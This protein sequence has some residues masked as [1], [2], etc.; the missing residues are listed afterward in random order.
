MQRIATL[1][2]AALAVGLIA[3]AQAAD[4][5]QV[6][7]QA[8]QNNG[9]FQAAYQTYLAAK[10]NVPIYRGPLLPQVSVTSAGTGVTRNLKTDTTTK[11]FTLN[12]T[13]VLF[14]YTAW[15]TY[16]QS[17]YQ[18]KFDTLTY[19]TAEQDLINT[20]AQDYFAVL[21][22][23]DNLAYALAYERSNKENLDQATEQFKVGLKAVTDV[24]SARAQYESAVAS[25]IAAQNTLQDAYQTLS[26]L[27][28]RAEISLNILKPDFPK[29]EPYP[30]EAKIWAK[31]AMKNNLSVLSDAEQ[32][33]IDT[34]GIKVAKSGFYPTL[35]LS[36]NYVYTRES[37]STTT[38]RNAAV[39]ASWS[40]Y[41]GGSTVHTVKQSEYTVKADQATYHQALRNV[42]SQTHS[43]YLT[44]LSDIS[45]IAAYNQ[46]V[47]AGEASVK[48]AKAQYQVGTTT[49]YNLLQ[50]QANLF[51]A[52]QE[53]AQAVYQYITDSLKLKTD[54]GQ[55]SVKDIQG[56]NSWL[57]TTK[58]TT[59]KA[60]SPSKPKKKASS[61]A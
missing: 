46:A 15:T 45:Q 29:V 44:V 11:A 6:Y 42:S 47:I 8:E 18:L 1:S 12:A 50:E 49:I 16:T 48:A 58:T 19:E 35:G 9:T 59:D 39:N 28:G 60:V 26:A 25:R 38:D 22:A 36:G 27:T 40:I 52:Q 56:I 4:L 41:S 30:A 51:Q 32:V 61:E 5:L 3:T 55:L 17:E 14:D 7:Q 33:A 34:A 57:D 10:E 37:G 43:D 13:Q 24:A 23:H 54:A 53:Y 21:Q 20:T 31:T 2:I